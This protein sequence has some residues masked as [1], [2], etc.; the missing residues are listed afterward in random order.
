MSGLTS[1]EDVTRLQVGS[2]SSMADHDQSAVLGGCGSG[3]I[4]QPT[5]TTEDGNPCE[6]LFEAAVSP[7]CE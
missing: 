5:I 3:A 4:D 6:S 1:N 2:V 7:S